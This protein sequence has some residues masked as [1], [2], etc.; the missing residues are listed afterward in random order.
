MAQFEIDIDLCFEKRR[1]F[2]VTNVSKTLKKYVMASCLGELQWEAR[3]KLGLK[4]D[5]KIVICLEKCGTEIDSEKSFQNLEEQTQIV[6]KEV[7]FFRK[8]IIYNMWSNWFVVF[9]IIVK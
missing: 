7:S 5:S 9:S 4:M 3:Q 6:A 8:P 2:K 1:L